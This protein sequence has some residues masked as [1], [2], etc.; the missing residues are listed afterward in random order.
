MLQNGYY[1]QKTRYHFPN[2]DSETQEQKVDITQLK[3]AFKAMLEISKRWD[4]P[5]LKQELMK[6]K[7]ELE[8]I[9]KNLTSSIRYAQ[10][11]QQAVLPS[12][13]F[14]KQFIPE[15]FILYLPRDIV[16]GDFYWIKQVNNYIAVVAADCTGHGVPGAFMSM[17]GVALLNEIVRLDK[18]PSASEILNELRHRLKL[19]LHQDRMMGR[20]ADGMD[21]AL[22]IIDL[23]KKDLQYAGA[24][25]PAYIVRKDKNDI[26]ELIHL[27]PDRMPVGV[28][29][30]EKSFSHQKFQLKTDDSLY[31]FSDGF[32]DQFG[33]EKGIK[34]KPGRF[35]E[36]LLS[37]NGATMSRQRELLFEEY[38]NWRSGTKQ[39]DDILVM[40]FKI[41][42]DY[43][44][45]DFF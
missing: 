45:I 43:G 6:Q 29:L 24:N 37:I 36:F 44:D 18:N 26:P 42:D 27:R 15:Y 21:M 28:H 31:L 16:S 14:W 12:P 20:G 35:R 5:T 3:P 25:S 38:D 34:Y 22:C 32:V 10:F 4:D 40:G 2:A 33:G 13:D 19:S 11:I 39:L 1:I 30:K 17:L 41:Q 7:D 9:N 8:K 23:E